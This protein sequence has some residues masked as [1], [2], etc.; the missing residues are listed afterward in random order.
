MFGL[1]THVTKSKVQHMS[2]QS[3]FLVTDKEAEII[4]R[5]SISMHMFGWF[6]LSS[7]FMVA[8]WISQFYF[9]LMALKWC[10]HPA[11]QDGN[12]W[13]KKQ[14]SYVLSK[15]GTLQYIF[16][17]QLHPSAASPTCTVHESWFV[18]A[19]RIYTK[20]VIYWLIISTI[21]YNKLATPSPTISIQNHISYLFKVISFTSLYKNK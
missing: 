13:E 5:T 14:R 7:I 8:L 20:L 21:N 15:M 11:S 17:V 1:K 18:Q 16:N 19:E 6:A 9:G 12:S 10:E 3:P 2:K 4:N